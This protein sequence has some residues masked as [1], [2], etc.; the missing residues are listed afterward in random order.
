LFRR[1]QVAVHH[2]LNISEIQVLLMEQR[3][4]YKPILSVYGCQGSAKPKP[5]LD[6]WGFVARATT[7]V[8]PTQYV[9]VGDEVLLYADEV[10][11]PE[12]SGGCLGEKSEKRAK[13]AKPVVKLPLST[14][15]AEWGDFT[16]EFTLVI[17]D[18]IKKTEFEAIWELGTENECVYWGIL[19]GNLHEVNPHRPFARQRQF[20][21][22][23][24][25]LEREFGDQTATKLEEALG[26]AWDRVDKK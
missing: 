3:C 8:V 23:L 7:I 6:K 1:F 4:G 25:C 5:G 24:L 26:L 19:C 18:M 10:A 22:L 16:R 15:P 12:F 14:V 11:D 2:T 13:A 9:T 20:E 21:A 17:Q